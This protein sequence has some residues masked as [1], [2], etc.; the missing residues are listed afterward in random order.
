M[1]NKRPRARQKN[2]TSG[3]RVFTDA[4]T[5]LVQVKSVQVKSTQADLAE[6]I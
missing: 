4:E 6:A 3:G 5:D 1:D 2:V